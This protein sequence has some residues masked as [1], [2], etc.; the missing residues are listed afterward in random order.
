[1]RWGREIVLLQIFLHCFS[2]SKPL[3]SEI[4]PSKPLPL[5]SQAKQWIWKSCCLTDIGVTVVSCIVITSYKSVYFASNKCNFHNYQEE[6][7]RANDANL[8]FTVSFI[9]AFQFCIVLASFVMLISYRIVHVSLARCTAEVAAKENS[10]L[11][12]AAWILRCRWLLLGWFWGV[13]E[14]I[15]NESVFNR[16]ECYVHICIINCFKAMIFCNKLRW[17]TYLRDTYLCTC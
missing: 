10:S 8:I 9:V 1:M 14:S 15:G 13:T 12:V 2:P 5:F 11:T 17:F 4:K 7:L 16:H 6:W 3:P